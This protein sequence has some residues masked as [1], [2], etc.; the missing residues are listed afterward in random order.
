MK[1]LCKFIK[2]RRRALLADEPGLG[3]TV[4][5]VV[6]HN[7][8]K[9]K[10]IITIV[11][12]CVKDDWVATWEKWDVHG[13][14][15]FCVQSGKHLREYAGEEIIVSSYHFASA[16]RD[17]VGDEKYHLLVDELHYCKNY[18]AQRTQAV[19][20]E[21]VPG[22]VTF[23][24]ITGTPLKKDVEGLHPIVDCCAPDLFGSSSQFLK[25]YS[26]PVWN[27]Y[28]TEY[29]GLKNAKDLRRRMRKFMV[30]RY[31][32]DVLPELPDK[33]Y[34]MVKC[35]VSSELKKKT[36]HYQK[37]VDALLGKKDV[38]LELP[39]YAECRKALALAKVP[40]V[41]DRAVTMFESG[42]GPVILFAHHKDVVA[43]LKEACEK[44]GV[45]VECAVGGMSEKARIS[46]K[47]RFQNGEIDVGILSITSMGI[48]ITLTRSSVVMFAELGNTPADMSQA[49]DRAHRF[50]QDKNV[51]IFFFIAKGTLESKIWSRIKQDMKMV[52]ELL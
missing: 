14:R 24:G 8:L 26:N 18:A 2:E 1:L 6:L 33:I 22:S 15:I 27:G 43:A 38:N 7:I 21:L 30:R 42:S 20:S 9:S 52:Q 39:S 28:A 51:Q 11:P 40:Q 3:K 50:G 31:K 29:R 49:I 45:V 37:A 48:G 41:V 5:A 35:E 47:N 4:Q 16:V 46:F 23:V 13:R 32:K 17:L 34:K 36:K 12:S 19:M 25:K 44:R 10:K